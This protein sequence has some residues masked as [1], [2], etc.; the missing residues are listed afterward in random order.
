MHLIQLQAPWTG[1]S[2]FQ[3]TPKA[4]ETEKAMLPLAE[5]G[6]TRLTSTNTNGI[7]VHRYPIHREKN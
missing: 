1:T 2:G 7:Y 5:Q 4:R 6:F 3:W